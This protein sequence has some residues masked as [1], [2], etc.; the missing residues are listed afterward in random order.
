VSG[1]LLYIDTSEVREGA[2]EELKDAIEELVEFVDANVPQ[3]LAYNVYLSEDG[4]EMTVV[5]LHVDAASLE[6]H[7]E[8]GAP[9]FRKLADLLTLSSIRVYGDP[10]E[11]ALTLLRDKARSLGS[12]DVIVHHPHAG[13]SR[14][15]T[16]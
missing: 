13:F 12:G 1:P 11:K 5:H 2:L 7:L 4:R 16:R 14:L 3:V 8:I 10:S 6:H 9:A 15:E